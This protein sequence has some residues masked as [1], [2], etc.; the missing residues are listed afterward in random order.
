MQ[1][2]STRLSGSSRR[3]PHP[4]LTLWLLASR[5]Q[6]QGN[7]SQQ[8]VQGLTLIECLVAIVVI[9]I[10]V[11]AITPPL[12][13]ATASRIQSRK[14]EK[15]NQVAQGELEPQALLTVPARSV[16]LV[17]RRVAQRVHRCT[18]LPPALVPPLIQVRLLLQLPILFKWMSMAIVSQST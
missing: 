1:V 4:A 15:A 2:S 7:R 18:L 10:T 5:N 17:Q 6:R 9:A 11:V 14:V 12:M 16:P 3:F 8:S 13:L